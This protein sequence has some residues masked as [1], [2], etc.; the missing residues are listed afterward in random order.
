MARGGRGGRDVIRSDAELAAA[1]LVERYGDQ[2]EV[3]AIADGSPAH[4]LHELGEAD[5]VD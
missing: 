4:A 2:I 5:G 1:T 3:R